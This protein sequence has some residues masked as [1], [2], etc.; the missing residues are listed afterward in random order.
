MIESYVVVVKATLSTRRHS[1]PRLCSH[2]LSLSL[3]LFK[4]KKN[5]FG[6]R[7]G[8]GQT[9]SFFGSFVRFFC[10]CFSLPKSDGSVRSRFVS[11]DLKKKKREKS[12]EKKTEKAKRKSTSNPISK[13]KKASQTHLASHL[14]ISRDGRV[15]IYKKHENT[16]RNTRSS[17]SSS[18]F[19][20]QPNQRSYLIRCALLKKKNSSFTL[21]KNEFF[22]RSRGKFDRV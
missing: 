18:L 15:Y 3:C 10:C 17:L 21:L 20:H 19:R 4:K 9:L 8:W 7:Y 6:R 1:L 12:F 13:S 11:P 14:L 2:F 16:H 5:F 22:C